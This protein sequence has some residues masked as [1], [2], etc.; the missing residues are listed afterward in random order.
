METIKKE[1]V[2]NK[3]ALTTMKNDIQG[4]NS[5]IDETKNHIQDLEYKEAKILNQ[6]RK[7]KKKES[8]QVKVV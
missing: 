1:S 2:R 7:R 4:I 3:N 8:K 6:N 5:R